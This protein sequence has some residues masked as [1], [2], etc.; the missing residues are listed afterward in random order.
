MSELQPVRLFSDGS[1]L[2]NPGPGGW[3]VLLTTMKKGERVEKML[4]GAVKNTTNN[5][6]EM[7]AA[8][9]GLNAL[10]RPAQVVLVTDS[11]YVI[12]GITEW[13]HGWKKRGWKN[14]KKKPVENRDLWEALDEAVSRHEVTWEWTRGHSGHPENE[15]VDVAAR[16]RA[17]SQKDAE[18]DVR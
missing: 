1:C 7:R 14:S 3:A 15:R 13:I 11:Q 6:M 12:K 8:I 9:E 2:N 18:D 5:R 16:E 10:K 17:I 4:T